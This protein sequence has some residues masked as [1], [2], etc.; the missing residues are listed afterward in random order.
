MCARALVFP[1]DLTE[2]LRAWPRDT[3]AALGV[4][5]EDVAGWVVSAADT[6]SDSD[7]HDRTPA[8]SSCAP[9]VHPAYMSASVH[10]P[11]C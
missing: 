1:A 11:Q 5:L 8:S 2:E 10:H 6:T 9:G 3:G 7:V 4:D